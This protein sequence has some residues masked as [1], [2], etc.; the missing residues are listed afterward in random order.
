MKTKRLLAALLILF[1]LS[2]SLLAGEQVLIDGIKYDIITK[3][4][5]AKVISNSYQGDIVIP[6]TVTYNGVECNVTAIDNSAFANCK[7]LKSVVVPNSVTEMGTKVF[8]ASYVESV[9]LGN[10]ISVINTSTFASCLNLSSVNIPESVIT[11]G[12]RAFLGCLSL[13]SIYI[14][15]NVETIGKYAFSNCTGFTRM[16]IGDGVTKIDDYAFA[17]CSSLSSVVFGPKLAWK[18]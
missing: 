17:G 11:I 14:P 9:T 16:I 8:S 1:T 18:R 2:T 6:E 4:K 12:E 7:Q 3:G 15:D 10:G 5:T 13:T